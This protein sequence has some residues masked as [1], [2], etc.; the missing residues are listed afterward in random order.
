MSKNNITILPKKSRGFCHK[1]LK[2]FSV[3]FGVIKVN[4]FI[5]GSLCKFYFLL[6]SYYEPTMFSK[7]HFYQ[8]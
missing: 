7:K 3:V 5:D 8:R 1:N 2:D 6:I 4:T